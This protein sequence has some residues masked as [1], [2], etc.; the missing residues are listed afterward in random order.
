MKL[1]NLFPVLVEKCSFICNK[2]ARLF[3]SV[4]MIAMFTAPSTALAQGNGQAVA[5][6]QSLGQN[7]VEYTDLEAAFAAAQNNDEIKLLAD[8]ALAADDT[9]TGKL[10][11]GDGSKETDVVLDLN[12][13][14]IS[15]TADELITITTNARLRILDSGTGGGIVTTGAKGILNVGVLDMGDGSVIG[16]TSGIY[17]QGA[18][19]ISGGTVSGGSYAL[20]IEQGVANISGGTFVATGTDGIGI[21]SESAI[22]FYFLGLP[23][24]D[25]TVA[26]IS[27]AKDLQIEF[28]PGS[29]D[30]P[31]KKIRV[32]VDNE[33]PY[34]FTSNYEIVTDADGDQIAPED[35]FVSADYGEGLI[36]SRYDSNSM[37]YEAAVA[38]LTEVIFPAGTSTYFDQRALALYDTNN[39]LKFYGIK[40]L[41]ESTVQ[42][43]EFKSKKF[44]ENSTVIVSNTSDAAITAKMV[45]AFEGPMASS[46]SNVA[47]TDLDVQDFPP[48][49]LDGTEDA[50]TEIFV[51]EGYE[52]FGFSG[53]SFVLLGSDASAAAHSGWLV[54]EKS[55]LPAGVSLLTIFW[56]YYT[57][58]A[59]WIS[60]EDG[61]FVYNGKEQKPKVTVTDSNGTDV[62]SSF[63][64]EY[65]NNTNAG[66]ATVT[67]TAIS[68]S[69]YVGSASKI[70]TIANAP[71]T[72]TVNDASK[73]KGDDDPVFSA[74][75]SGLFGSDNLD[76]TLSRAVGED[77]GEY[78]ITVQLVGSN[79]NYKVT[80]TEGTF[81]IKNLIGDHVL[82][83]EEGQKE[84]FYPLDDAVVDELVKNSMSQDDTQIL[85]GLED[86]SEEGES[87]DG[88]A[89]TLKNALGV[90]V[91]QGNNSKAKKVVSLLKIK[92]QGKKTKIATV[93]LIK[94]KKLVI[95]VKGGKLKLSSKDKKKIKKLL[96]KYA[97]RAQKIKVINSKTRGE[98]PDDED[99]VFDP[100][101]EYEILED[102]DL[103]FTVEFDDDAEEMEIE[104]II[105]RQPGDANGDGKVDAADIVEMVNAKEGNPTGKNF[106]LLNADINEDGEGQITQED[107]DVVV[108]LIM[109]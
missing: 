55:E 58:E 52:V 2:S 13:H 40:G 20:Y 3:L 12:G 100:T 106:N 22:G 88:A 41:T 72:V 90:I 87:G 16:A 63:T 35:V 1:K 17:S 65:Q 91:K 34:T 96:K 31:V 61:T 21:E 104:G 53:N 30:V 75:V 19:N 89:A 15:G 27:L 38:G 25:C 29:F 73:F 43:A 69:Q 28:A 64:C 66:E 42:L 8:C 49:F 86:D 79:P 47:A 77:V 60:L 103:V 51:P 107:I 109:E 4:V 78:K 71:V 18:A 95:K 94:G 81:T 9:H 44:G 84:Q 11:L 85:F 83:G 39:N 93:N 33:A 80:V 76:Y 74:T 24:F 23:T 108:D 14:T 68:G 48:I 5:T 70:F 50:L 46:F 32:K 105:L 7:P 98:A 45:V 67:V 54:A 37:H 92:L 62:T 26:D 99:L 36:G 102:C 6:V 10:A 82:I 97:K 56:P 59:S 57:L 101:I